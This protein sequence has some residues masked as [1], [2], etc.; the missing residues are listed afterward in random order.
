MLRLSRAGNPKG[1]NAIRNR[2]QGMHTNEAVGAMSLFSQQQSTR[3]GGSVLIRI[4]HAKPIGQSL[5]IKSEESL[6]CRLSR[7][8]RDPTPCHSAIARCTDRRA[9]A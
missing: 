1:L 7:E 8:I 9:T 5:D 6:H 4:S 2:Q 3:E